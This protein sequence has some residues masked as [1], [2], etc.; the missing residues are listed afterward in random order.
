MVGALV[1]RAGDDKKAAHTGS[2]KIWVRPAKSKNCDNFLRRLIASRRPRL[3]TLA[4]SSRTALATEGLGV[5]IRSVKLR[6]FARPKDPVPTTH[7]RIRRSKPREPQ[8]WPAGTSGA[9]ASS[10]ASFHRVFSPA[11]WSLGF[12]L[13]SSL[14]SSNLKS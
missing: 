4:L 6:N 14:L 2:L 7:T 3:A 5:T 12:I 1:K 13:A 11:P 9:K 8:R 10:P